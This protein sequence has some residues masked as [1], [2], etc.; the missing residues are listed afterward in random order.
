VGALLDRVRVEGESDSLVDEIRDLGLAYG[1]VTPYTTFVISGQAEGA[2]SADN[3]ALYDSA[4]INE[5]WGRVT[6]RARVQNQAYQETA[7]AGLAV[8][9]NVQNYGGQSLAQVGRRQ[10]DLSLLLGQKRLDDPIDDLW[11][12]RNVEVDRTIEFGSHEYF[13]LA[14]DPVARAYLQ[15]GAN[16]LFEY[17]GEIISVH[18]PDHQDS[19]PDQQQIKAPLRTSSR[20][21]PADGSG[22][23]ST[24]LP[25]LAIRGLLGLLLPLAAIAAVV[26]V[27]GMLIPAILVLHHAARTR[28]R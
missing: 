27:L 25:R 18:D 8:G 15:S 28:P 2:A 12:E 22:L 13:A 24:G 11:I 6:I 10:F 21:S 14:S 20:I 23:R 1:I 5:A 19:E 3:M 4:G 26:M 7:Q 9:A 17:Q 16:V